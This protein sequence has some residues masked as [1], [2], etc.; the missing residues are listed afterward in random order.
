MS[1]H[2]LLAPSASA[3][4]LNCPA[5]I[6]AVQKSIEVEYKESDA[7]REGTAAHEFA[8]MFLPTPDADISEALDFGYVAENGIPIDSEMVKYLEVYRSYCYEHIHSFETMK[9]YCFVEYAVPLF[10]RPEDNGTVDFI[11]YM[12][13]QKRL[14]IIDLKY[15]RGLVEAVDNTQL[16]IYVISAL[17]EFEFMF[18]IESVEIHIGQPRRQNFD[19]QVLT[20]EELEEW[21]EKITEVVSRIDSGE[22]YKEKEFGP[23]DKACQWCPLAGE[24]RA[25]AEDIFK[26]LDM[27]LELSER[28]NVIQLADRLTPEDISKIL[29]RQKEIE[30]FLKK[31]HAL[32]T[33]MA[34]RGEKVPGYKLVG[35][36]TNRFW[37][38]QEG[39]E[40]LLAQ[41][42]KKDER[43][44]SK[45]ISP[46]QAEKLLGKLDISS[47]YKAK[48]EG[49]ISRGEGKPALVP[50]S[51]I[52]PEY[53]LYDDLELMA[54]L[55]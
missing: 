17:D 54:A 37:N 5:S 36:L 24:C 23:S 30:S 21:R 3:R 32:A 22:A 10:Y 40:K 8:E 27:D 39:V 52:R 33:D 13:D 29:G 46:A 26:D 50:D 31:V 55:E 38:D 49:F 1:T 51:D 48:F 7:A 35:T 18:D 45:F 53:R 25:Q 34:S 6:E 14:H 15:G 4:W 42:L 44:P 41:K 9:K 47:R 2:S 12:P 19:S 28:S 16:I 43:Y 20:L 11:S